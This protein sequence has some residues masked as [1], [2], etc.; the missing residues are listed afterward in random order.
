MQ[1]LELRGLLEVLLDPSD[2]SLP[3]IL[4]DS[5]SHMPL[6]LGKDGESAGQGVLLSKSIDA[7]R[8]GALGKDEMWRP[9]S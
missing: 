8:L 3:Q 2:G 7:I 5:S 1:A 4:S 6:Y 9:T